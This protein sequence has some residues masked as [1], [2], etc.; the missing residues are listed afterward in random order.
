MKASCDS[1]ALNVIPSDSA[2]GV[3]TDSSVAA[4]PAVVGHV[5]ATGRRLLVL[6]IASAVENVLG[7]RDIRGGDGEDWG[8]A[9]KTTTPSLHEITSSYIPRHRWIAQLNS[10]AFK[11]SPHNPGCMRLDLLFGNSSWYLHQR[12][13]LRTYCSW[14][15]LHPSTNKIVYT[16]RIEEEWADR[17]ERC[18]LVP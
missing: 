2:A 13:M 4:A 12:R 5:F 14:Y 11:V 16:I 8:V 17:Y 15:V 3:S 18:W 6:E 7:S 10:W 9:E 1:T